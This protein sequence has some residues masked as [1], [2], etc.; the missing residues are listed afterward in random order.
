[1]HFQ[2]IRNGDEDRGRQGEVKDSVAFVEAALQLSERVRQLLKVWTVFILARYVGAFCG[3][4]FNE[5]FLG[6]DLGRDA[7]CEI[8]RGQLGARVSDNRKAFWHVLV[9]VES[10][11][12]RECL[13]LRQITRSPEN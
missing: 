9:L 7:G 12:S 11:K 8:R 13:L 1:M 10:K 6:L 2:V 4:A 5:S 3:E